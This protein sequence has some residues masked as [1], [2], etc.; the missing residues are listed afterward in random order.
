MV[1][2]VVANSLISLMSSLKLMT[3]PLGALDEADPDP[4]DDEYDDEDDDEDELELLG[5]EMIRGTELEF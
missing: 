5:V 1:G 4:D 3:G 2:V